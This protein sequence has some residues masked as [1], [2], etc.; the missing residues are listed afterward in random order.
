MKVSA[1]QAMRVVFITQAGQLGYRRFIHMV[2]AE[3]LFEAGQNVEGR[4]SLTD[5]PN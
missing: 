5:P 3:R 1:A 4:L 2:N